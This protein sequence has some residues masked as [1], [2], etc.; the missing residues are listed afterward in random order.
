MTYRHSGRLT[1]AGF[2]LSCFWTALAH[3]AP[4][5][6]NWDVVPHEDREIEPG[7]SPYY[8]CQGIQYT[9]RL[10]SSLWEHGLELSAAQFSFYD[11]KWFDGFGIEDGGG[12]IIAPVCLSGLTPCFPTFT[13]LTLRIEGTSNAGPDPNLFI[14][15]SRGGRMEI[16]SLSGL[17][18][19][20]FAGSEWEDLAWLEFGFYLADECYGGDPPEDEDICDPA[21]EKAFVVGDLTFEHPPSVPE[22]ALVTLLAAGFASVGWRRATRRHPRR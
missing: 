14:R 2:V 16:P 6:V 21:T 20:H 22:P 4:I 13:P 9:N 10:C 19:I 1:V 11:D 7:E 12:G 3:A 8:S 18:S 15:S 5:T 17:A